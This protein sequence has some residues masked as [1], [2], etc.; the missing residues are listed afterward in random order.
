MFSLNHP[1]CVPFLWVSTKHHLMSDK[2]WFRDLGCCF[3]PVLQSK[4]S[5]NLLLSSS[6]L[7]VVSNNWRK[8]CITGHQH[9]WL[10][11]M[12]VE[13]HQR[14]SSVYVDNRHACCRKELFC[15]QCNNFV[16]DGCESPSEMDLIF[17]VSLCK[18]ANQLFL[19][20]FAHLWTIN[21]CC[22]DLGGLANCT[23]LYCWKYAHA[24]IILNITLLP[25]PKMQ[26]MHREQL[27]KDVAVEKCY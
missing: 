15:Y 22:Y 26:E 3:I 5:F 19:N 27:R 4:H 24:L 14:C 13:E 11:G 1:H 25:C 23:N 8:V 9:P 20:K 6:S 16:Q 7:K 18:P 2:Q 10:C 12:W 21:F 17:V